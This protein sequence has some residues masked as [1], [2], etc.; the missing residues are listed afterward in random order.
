MFGH[1]KYV[2]KKKA[3]FN[4]VWTYNVKVVDGEKKA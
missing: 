4:L 2:E 3:I 1:P